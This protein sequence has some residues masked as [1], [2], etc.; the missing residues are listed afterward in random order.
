MDSIATGIQSST[1]TFFLGEAKIPV[2]NKPYVEYLSFPTFFSRKVRPSNI[3][4]QWK[5]YTS[6]IFKYELCTSDACV[7]LNIIKHIPE[8][9]TSLDI[10][11]AAKVSLAMRHNEP[12]DPKITASLLLNDNE[13][14]SRVKLN[15]GY[16]FSEQSTKL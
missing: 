9:K 10:L 14:S 12:K 2:F 11:Y 15:G 5:V 8:V 6:E 7:P 4:R 1:N 13:C 16:A 3:E